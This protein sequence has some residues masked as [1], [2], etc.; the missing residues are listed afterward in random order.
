MPEGAAILAR[1]NPAVAMSGERKSTQV[2]RTAAMVITHEMAPESGMPVKV[3]GLS[4]HHR[5]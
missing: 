2:N 1:I 4:L 3:A 5:R